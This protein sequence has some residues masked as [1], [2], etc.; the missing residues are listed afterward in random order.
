[1][2]L[3]KR[4][5]IIAVV[6]LAL[7]YLAG[8]YT[9]PMSTK[10][11]ITQ[12]EKSKTKEEESTEKRTIK[13]EIVHPD[14]TKETVIIDE[15]IKK[16][17]ETEETKKETKIVKEETRAGSRTTL[18]AL[19]GTKVKLGALEPVYG[20]MVTRD[21]IGPIHVGAFGLSSGVG[22]IAVGVSF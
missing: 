21:I 13:K 19:A 9:A 16:K 6:A 7:A 3:N 20:G 17:K 15:D 10:T 8:R 2:E 22:G 1:M 18:S 11:D 4:N 12:N 5:I 14:G